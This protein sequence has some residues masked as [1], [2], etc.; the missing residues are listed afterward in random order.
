MS[1]AIALAAR[2]LVAIGAP[3][4]A[5]FDAGSAEATV[6]G[7]LYDGVRDA[8]LS[9]HPWSF[10]TAQA[11]LAR[12]ALEPVADFQHAYQL[13]PDLLRVLSAGRG[14]VYRIAESMLHTDAD[15][16]V[17]TYVFRPDES[18]FPAFFD[19]ALTAR[20]A[21]ELCL[22]LTESAARAEL[23]HRLAEQEFRRA[24]LIDAQQDT[25]PALDGFPLAQVRA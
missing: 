7:I 25:A 15:E 24:R 16:V 20:L 22:P 8:L 2:A 14:T 13:P 21:A 6:A 9:A 23:L 1:T 19:Q 17:L 10:A 5:S 4:S 12:L 3:P 11:S 18:A